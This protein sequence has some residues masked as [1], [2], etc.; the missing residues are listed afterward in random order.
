MTL[1]DVQLALDWAAAEGWNPGLHDA[2]AFHSADPDGFWMAEAQGE[3]VGCISTVCYD[4]TFA[5]IGLFIVKQG[6]RGRGYGKQLWQTAWQHLETRM[7]ATQSSIGLD[8][9]LDREA[10]YRNLGF[11]PVYRHIR[12]AYYSPPSDG[13][14]SGVV[15][16][17]DIPF[18]EVIRYDSELFPASRPQF[19]KPWLEIPGGAAYGIVEDGKLQGYGILRPC[20]QGF[21]IGPLFADSRAIAQSLLSALGSHAGSQPIFVDV[22]ESNPAIA[23]FTQNNN[24]RPVFSC[25]RM[26]CGPRPSHDIKRVFG[27]TTLELG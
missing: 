23:S 18:A 8:S 24:M 16:L 22:P 12:H 17:S 14:P 25:V 11:I 1:Q 9:V 26:Y 13:L 21:K 5:F 20:R 10:T 27:V 6:W 2:I 15:P 4:P 7:D 19:L 3:P